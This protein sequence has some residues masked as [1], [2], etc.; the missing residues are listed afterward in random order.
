MDWPNCEA[1][2]AICWRCGQF[3]CKRHAAELEQQPRAD[4]A[5]DDLLNY[6]READAYHTRAIYHDR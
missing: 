3:S 1:P 5:L 2:F 6:S 4:R